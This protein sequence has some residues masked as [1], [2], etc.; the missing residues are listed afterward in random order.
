[1]IPYGKHH[2]DSDDIDAVVD[3]LENHFLTQGTKVPEFEQA[4]CDYTGA[5]YC[6][7]VNS[8]TSGLHV[9]CLAA[10]VEAGDLVWSTP[11]SFV[12]S[13]NCAL[14]CNAKV[15]FIDMDP[16]TRNIDIEKLAKRVNAAKRDNA[17]PKAIIVVHFAGFSCDMQ[18]ISSLL[19]DTD[20]VL[21]E[22]AAHGLG[23]SYHG[24]KIG[25]CEFS[26]MSVLSFH[27]VKSITTAEGGAVMTNSAEFAE[28][29]VLFAKHGVTRNQDLF[30]GSPEALLQ[31]GPWYYQ[32]LTLGYNYRLS[33]MQAALGISQL[34]KLDGFVAAR[35][36]CADFYF[37]KLK[38]LPVVLPID[39]KQ[40]T[41]TNEKGNQSGWHLFM[42]EL[43]DDE[44]CENAEAISAKR[45][46]VFEQLQLKGIGVNV[47][48]I[49]IHLHPYYQS[50]GFKAGD[51]PCAERFYN[52]AITLPL[53][54]SLTEQEQQK[55]VDTLTEILQ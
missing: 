33:D 10:G 6:T 54:P 49:P 2:V 51:Y 35:Q 13:A 32:Q 50:L 17:L 9:A 52:R 26:D 12:A 1:M 29:L 47:H 20:V 28:R 36:K 40:T 45:K 34:K 44:N 43:L 25:S 31:Q 39:E 38:G 48:Y 8:A 46:H 53:Y 11:N 27:P 15:D 55:V 18:R 3:V 7:A 23:G 41:T 14:Y 24:K 37:E 22:D 16:A 19:K 4:L 5:K 30:E 42:I 21:I